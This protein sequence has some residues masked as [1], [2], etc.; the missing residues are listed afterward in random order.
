MIV[1]IRGSDSHTPNSEEELNNNEG[2]NKSPCR[3]LLTC[4]LHTKVVTPSK[5]QGYLP[6]FMEEMPG[7]GNFH[8]ISQMPL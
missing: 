7:R 3:C 2:K 5:Y 8:H 6:E 4:I 1:G